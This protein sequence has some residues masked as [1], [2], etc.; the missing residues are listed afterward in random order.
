[1]AD[2]KL[3]SQSLLDSVSQ[4]AKATVRQ[5]KNYN[6]HES[7][8]DICHRLLN[9]LEPD[10]YI[11]PHRH[12]HPTK[13][14][15]IVI[16]RGKVGL[17]LFDADGEITQRCILQT[18]SDMLGVDIPPGTFHS[19]VALL[20]DTVFFEVKAGPYVALA[21]NERANWAPAEDSDRAGEYLA[22]MKHSFV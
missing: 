10:T 12:L 14:E 9:A 5:R 4:S 8:R 18:D 16:L 13:A 3:I 11:P 19:M 1:M 22:W 2:V 17:L 21:V 7:D 6:F 20:P 15:S